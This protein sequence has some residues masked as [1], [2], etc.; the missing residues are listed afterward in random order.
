MTDAVT[1]LVVSDVRFRVSV[2]PGVQHVAAPILRFFQGALRPPADEAPTAHL[3]LRPYAQ[4]EADRHRALPSRPVIIRR[5]TAAPFNLDAAMSRDGHWLHYLNAHTLL[6]L[7]RI[8]EEGNT[9]ILAAISQRSRVQMV[10]FIRNWLIRLLEQ[11]GVVFL[12]AS[13]ILSP[14]GVVAFLGPKGAGKTTALLSCLADGAAYFTGDKLLL[15]WDGQQVRSLPWWD[16]PHVGL[17]TLRGF[18][19]L[20]DAVQHVLPSD[21]RQRPAS[22]KVLLE[23]ELFAG[24][25][26]TAWAMQPTSVAG[27]VL[28]DVRPDAP[29][30]C[31]K[32]DV[33]QAW[34]AVHQNLERIMATTFSTWQGVLVPDGVAVH[35]NLHA[36]RSAICDIPVL[37][38]SGRMGRGC[39][40]R[41]YGQ[42]DRALGG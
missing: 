21:W 2:D 5:S 4:A 15:I 3:Y 40:E 12:H 36:M 22:E 34:G 13:A 28:V 30:E 24:W 32:A 9:P 1:D 37:R 41:I 42:L 25:H 29:M 27:W 11:R 23:P 39:I 8:W 17:G 19:D 14:R 31:D 35:H 20:A 6:S 26:G 33:S 10:D 7:P 16:W 38:L 18:P